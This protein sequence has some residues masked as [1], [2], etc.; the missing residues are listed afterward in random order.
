[1][2]KMVKDY[3]KRFRSAGA[4]YNCSAIILKMWEVRKK[5][6]HMA[7]KSKNSATSR[8]WSEKFRH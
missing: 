4:F 6:T 3:T 1:M 5:H 8:F 7:G 2:Q